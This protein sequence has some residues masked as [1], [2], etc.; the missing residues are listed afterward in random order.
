MLVDLL[1][2]RVTVERNETLQLKLRLDTSTPLLENV[3]LK[4][5]ANIIITDTTS[6][7]DV[8]ISKALSLHMWSYS[9]G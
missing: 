8:R 7:Y 4:D 5:T 3:F 6:K 9:R 1:R 2:D